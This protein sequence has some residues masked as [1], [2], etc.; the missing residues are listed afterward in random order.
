MTGL[1][2]SVSFAFTREFPR[3]NSLSRAGKQRRPVDLSPPG[4]DL[5]QH[6]LVDSG[7]RDFLVKCAQGASAA[8]VPSGLR[9][10]ALP[11]AHLPEVRTTLPGAGE[12]HLRPHYRA[13]LPIETTLLKTLAGSDD[14]ITE[15]YHDQIA[16]I[17]VKWSAGLLESP[18]NL[19]A[20][21]RILSP[22]FSGASFR[23]VGSRVLRSGPAVEVHQNKFARESPLG[24]DAFLRE[25]RSA[26]ASF[27]TIF[28]AEF[29]VTSIDAGSQPVSSTGVPSRLQTGVRYELVGSAKEFYREQRVGQWDM[30]W[31]EL[32]AG[33]CRLR[34]WRLSDET[35]SR[36]AS[37]IFADITAQALAGNASYSSQLLHGADY[38]RTVLDVACGIDIYGHNGVSVG[39]I[40]DD[41]FDDLYVCQPA[42]L[43]N[44]LYRNR[45]DGTFDD[46]TESS[47]LGVLENTACA[48]FADFDNDGRQDLI[49]VRT[50]GP[51]LFVNQGGGKFRLQPDALQFA[52]APQG[53]FTGAAVADL[54]SG[55]RPVQISFSLL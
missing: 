18:Q 8:L 53:T 2:D 32:P 36:S 48:L 20:I 4:R 12:F 21:E 29:Q 22:D 52:Q 23:P 3:G 15:K 6:D 9:G 54:L 33:E 45:G 7:R 40:D 1:F 19:Q 30:E 41:G 11:F 25:L 34:S 31:E 13:K 55:R 37:P 27:S 35:Q 16:A 44:R 10:F 43:P 14:F 47:G 50:N 17:L 5:A 24:R 46:V 26:M 39:D 51:L 42:G 49:V 28:T 38:W